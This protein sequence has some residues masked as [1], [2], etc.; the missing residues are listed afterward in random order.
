MMHYRITGY[1]GAG[2]TLARVC[3]NTVVWKNR[4]AQ[5]YCPSF[6]E[7]KHE[8]ERQLGRPIQ[9]HPMRWA[10]SSS[11]VEVEIEFYRSRE[12][13]QW[14]VYREGPHYGPPGEWGWVDIGGWTDTLAAAKEAVE[15][16]ITNLRPIFE[17]VGLPLVGRHRKESE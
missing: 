13:F 15:A 1:E 14:K 7:A 17:A 4:P 10:A 9:W 5:G 3:Y 16:V 11:G 8:C 6:A 12:R 2:F